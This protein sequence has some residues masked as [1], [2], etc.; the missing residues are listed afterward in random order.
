MADEKIEVEPQ[1][2]GDSQLSED[3]HMSDGDDTPFVDAATSIRQESPVCRSDRAQAD[4]RSHHDGH[5]HGDAELSHSDQSEQPFERATEPEPEEAAVISG[6]AFQSGL[7]QDDDT[8]MSNSMADATGDNEAEATRVNGA[9]TTQT[10]L[11]TWVTDN[12]RMGAESPPQAVEVQGNPPPGS[13]RVP[14]TIDVHDIEEAPVVQSRD[15]RQRRPAKQ[16][17]YVAEV[18]ETAAR[19]AASTADL[20]NSMLST[21]QKMLSRADQA[22]ANETEAKTALRLATKLMH[23]FNVTRA[24][25]LAHDPEGQQQYTGQSLVNIRRRDLNPNKSVMMYV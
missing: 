8:E 15:E 23:R 21:I 4:G 10:N 19:V 17:I 13:S 5:L 1:A 2:G 12:A 20:D 11:P 22:G 18:G 16:S 24:E 7:T 6:D 3:L 14:I 25:V 9:N